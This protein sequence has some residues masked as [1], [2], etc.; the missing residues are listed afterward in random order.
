M[1]ASSSPKIVCLGNLTVDDVTLPD[2]TVRLASTGGNT[3]YAGL[4]ARLWEPATAIVA[5]VGSDAP[6]SLL[7]DI[8]KAGFDPIGLPRRECLTIHNR[9]RYLTY[10]RRQ[11]QF[12]SPES[13]FYTLSPL[14][15]DIPSGF[16]NAEAFLVLAMSLEAQEQLVPWLRSN[17]QAIIALDPKEDYIS[18]NEERIFALVSM[19]DLFMPSESEVQQLMG[20][21]EWER[22]AQELSSLGPKIVVI[23]RGEAGSLIYRSHDRE[24]KSIGAFPSRVID[25]TGAGD[26]YCGGFLARFLEF[27]TDLEAA[28][29]AGAISASFAVASFG[30]DALLEADA[31]QA[32]SRLCL[33]EPQAARGEP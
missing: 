17:T 26:A 23:K 24:M 32:T 15:V 14:P 7:T 16:R 22:A 25:T 5:P 2:G 31:Q 29:R 8:R 10:D 18:G 1:L 28:G 27:P 33:W 6:D 13:A 12:L 3:L 11:W 19:V 30:I 4:G 9:V 20:H 21:V